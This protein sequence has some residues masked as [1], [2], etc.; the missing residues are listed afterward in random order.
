MQMLSRIRARK[1]RIRSA[2]KRADAESK[3]NKCPQREEKGDNKESGCQRLY[4]SKSR[5]GT[6]RAAIKRADAEV[7][8]QKA[9]HRDGTGDS[10]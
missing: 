8:Q 4:R 2:I 1:W 9:S 5:R 3:Q 7:E 6:E 10:E